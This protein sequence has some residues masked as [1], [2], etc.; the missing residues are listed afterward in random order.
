MSQGRVPP[1]CPYELCWEQSRSEFCAVPSPSSMRTLRTPASIFPKAF[2]LLSAVPLRVRALA[3]EWEK[4]RAQNIGP[5]VSS[6]PLDWSTASA[7]SV[8]HPYT[9]NE[10]GVCTWLYSK[11]TDCSC[12]GSGFGSPYIHG[13]SQLT[14]WN[15]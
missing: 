6:E 8:N 12:R 2:P 7:F 11:N 3:C 15:S 13:N 1:R 14:V 10:I 4:E 9:K 5:A